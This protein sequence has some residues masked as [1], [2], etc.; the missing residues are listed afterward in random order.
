MQNC[1]LSKSS[2]Y[3]KIINFCG[4]VD[5][6]TTHPEFIDIVDYFL[7]SENGMD[8]LEAMFCK[9]TAS[10]IRTIIIPEKIKIFACPFTKKERSIYD[11]KELKKDAVKKLN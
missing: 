6:P 11:A 5:E 8:M 2:Q 4:S 10:D 9:Q 1:K 7:D 3:L